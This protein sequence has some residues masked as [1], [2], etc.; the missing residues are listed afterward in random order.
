MWETC[1]AQG[2]IATVGD[3]PCGAWLHYRL[4]CSVVG[5]FDTAVQEQY[6]K[7]IGRKI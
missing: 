1:T 2:V 3:R 5:R 4:P 7:T 6:H